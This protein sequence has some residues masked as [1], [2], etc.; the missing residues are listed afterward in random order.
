MDY[1]RLKETLDRFYRD[2]DFDERLQHDP[3]QFPRLYSDPRDIEVAAFI[4]SSLAYGRVD[5]F[6]P[7]IRNILSRMGKSPFEFIINFDLR[8]R[9]LFKDIKY[10]F[11][12]SD[13]I[14]CLLY[15]LSVILKRYGSLERLFKL[16]L[17]GDDPYI[18][19]G[20]EGMIEEILRID[21][22]V[23]YGKSSKPK[24]FLQFFPSPKKGSACKRANLFLRWM[25]RDRDIDFGIW[26]D[27][28]RNKLVIPLDV[29]IAKISMCL[30]FTGRKVQDWKTAVEVTE[31][32]RILD[33]EDPL[34]YD[35]ALCHHGISKLCSKTNC[36]ECI[37]FELSNRNKTKHRDASH[38]S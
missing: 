24:G 28:G 37:F 2:Y 25:I 14:F 29:H 36:R 13:D 1:N 5:L 23:I 34:K 19:S 9:H 3:I 22:S 4:S 12:L 38:I 6:I 8:E 26:H 30:G 7:V 35:F 31:S 27:V 15:V 17:R 33:P 11:N 20:L 16:Y 10:R 21:T 18:T 32:L